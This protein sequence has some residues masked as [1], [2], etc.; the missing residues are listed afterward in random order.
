MLGVAYVPLLAAFAVLLLTRPDGVGLVITLIGGVAAYDTLAYFAGRAFGR[1]RIAPSISPGKTIEG[2]IG[3]TLGTVVVMA[4]AAPRLG[5]WDIGQAAILG[6]A[7]CVMAPLGDLFES[8]LKRDLG[9]KDT[10]VLLPG[11][12]GALDRIDAILFCAPAV[13]A[14]LQVFGL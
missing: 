2:T 4:F 7:V 1:R 11:H 14:S 13:Y 8:L 6:A 9:I 12:G 10:G 3:A 5:P